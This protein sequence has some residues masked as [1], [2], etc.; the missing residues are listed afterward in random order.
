MAD[1]KIPRSISTEAFLN[2][3]RCGVHDAVLELMRAGSSN[4]GADFYTL[5]WGFGET[6]AT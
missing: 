6:T 4:P 5:R 2:Q 3:I 1:V